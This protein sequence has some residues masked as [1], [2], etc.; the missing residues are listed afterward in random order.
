MDTK[1]FIKINTNNLRK[2]GLIKDIENDK[3]LLTRMILNQSINRFGECWF[4][5]ETIIEKSNLK[6]IKGKG[7]SI[8]QYK[9]IIKYLIVTEELQ[10]NDIN[11]DTLK[12]NTMIKANY[13]PKFNKND[14]G[15]D[16]NFFTIEV[17]NFEKILQ[18]KNSIKI[19]YIYSYLLSRIN[20]T[21]K[22]CYPKIED[23]EDDIKITD[24]YFTNA[25]G[26]LNQLGLIY[27]DNIGQITKNGKHKTANNVYSTSTT[28]LDSGL[29][30]SRTYW[31]SEGWTILNKKQSKT[32]LQANA[33]K[34]TIKREQAKGKDVNKL[35]NKLKKL[36]EKL[37]KIEGKSINDYRKEINDILNKTCD[38]YDKNNLD[39]DID[40]FED[41]DSYI[42]DIFNA[43]IDEYKEVLSYVKDLATKVAKE[44]IKN[45]SNAFKDNTTKHKGIRKSCSCMEEDYFEFCRQVENN[46]DKTIENTHIRRQS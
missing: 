31:K 46:E 29:N 3:L 25:I 40:L 42:K 35:E 21:T 4:D 45:D 13:V 34:S 17:E 38:L 39:I 10:V 24:K 22:C 16:T 11:I 33:I 32:I 44:V 20:N 41:V 36:E 2:E 14:K 9:N 1:N 27:N 12:I 6:A 18:Q 30:S 19:M 43:T 26:E 15:E 23:V 8:E 5:I 28:Y 7:K 37:P